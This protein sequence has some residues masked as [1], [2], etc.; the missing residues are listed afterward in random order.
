M[1]LIMEPIMELKEWAKIQQPK[2]LKVLFITI[3][4]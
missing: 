3:Y 1:E 2:E 4:C